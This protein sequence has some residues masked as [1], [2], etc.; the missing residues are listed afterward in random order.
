MTNGPRSFRLPALIEQHLAALSK[1]YGQDGRR[2]LQQL[3]VNAGIRIHEES[4]T[5]NWNGGTFGHALYLIL[6]ESLFLPFA[7][8]KDEVQNEIRAGLNRI[9]SVPDEYI[10][11]VFLE[12]SASGDP[13]WRKNS[14]LLVSQ[15]RLPPPEATTRIWGNNGYRVFLSHKSEVKTETAALKEKLRIFGV[16][17][18]VAHEDIHPTVAWQDELENAL[19]TMDALVALMTPNFHDSDW[20][21]QEVGFAFARGIPIIAVRL[22]RDPYGFIGKFQALRSDWSTAPEEIVKLLLKNEGMFT[23][24]VKALGI[25]SSW[26]NGNLIAKALPGL[27]RLTAEQVNSLV[28]AYNETSELRG[29]FGFNGTKSM[30]YGPGLV[31]HLN[32]LGTQK[33]KYDTDRLILPE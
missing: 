28:A 27:S 9:H 12:L 24:Y 20:T 21:D 23:A 1:L 29:S 22:G 6:P 18:F 3:L 10:S 14:G 11:D 13:E 25:C 33:F 16:S 15:A 17:C 19:G 30:F 2:D 5:D 31:H 26:D 8:Q 32:R 4:A 7:T